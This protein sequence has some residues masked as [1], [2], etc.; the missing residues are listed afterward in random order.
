MAQYLRHPRSIP[1]LFHGTPW[2][3]THILAK[4]LGTPTTG[5]SVGLPPWHILLLFLVW[6]AVR[7][8]QGAGGRVSWPDRGR[9]RLTSDQDHPL[10]IVTRYTYFKGRCGQRK[11]LTFSSRQEGG[12]KTKHAAETVIGMA[13]AIEKKLLLETPLVYV[14]PSLKLFMHTYTQSFLFHICRRSSVTA[15]LYFQTAFSLGG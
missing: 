10:G 1:L 9:P 3:L 15:A 14:V 12:G 13:C 8:S 11:L 5:T 2:P 4:H 7:Y 6:D